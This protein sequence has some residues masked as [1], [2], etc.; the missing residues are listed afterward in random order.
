MCISDISASLSTNLGDYTTVELSQSR[1][2][3]LSQWAWRPIAADGNASCSVFFISESVQS[4][5][6]NNDCVDFVYLFLG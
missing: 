4:K 6:Q 2:P 1:L 5:D 3:S